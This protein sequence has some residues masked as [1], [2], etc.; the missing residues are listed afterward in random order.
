V[1]SGEI[2]VENDP[3]GAHS[4]NAACD[5]FHGDEAVVFSDDSLPRR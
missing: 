1:E 3:L 4:E 2:G 5:R